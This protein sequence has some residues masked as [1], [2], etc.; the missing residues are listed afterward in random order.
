[1]DTPV[2]FFSAS[3][4]DQNVQRT[5]RVPE[6]T[7]IN[8]AATFHVLVVISRSYGSFRA[9]L[10]VNRGNK[11]L[12]ALPYEDV[13]LAFGCDYTVRVAINPTEPIVGVTGTVVYR[14]GYPTQL[15]NVP[16]TPDI[17]WTILTPRTVW[18]P[19][20]GQNASYEFVQSTASAV[21]NV[22]HSLGKI[23]SVTIIDSANDEIVGD[24]KHTSRNTVVIT[25]SAAVSGRAVFN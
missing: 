19:A 11:W 10:Y 25:F 18:T 16:A 21:W 5:V 4:S 14:N 22:T 13:D 24:V 8:A 9:G 20:P 12:F 1:M 3:Y 6:Y 17:I 15:T 7:Q 23:P 2:R